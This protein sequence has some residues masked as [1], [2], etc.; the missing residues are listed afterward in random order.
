M[1]VQK[2]G[3]N[4]KAYRQE[5]QQGTKIFE[6]SFKGMQKAEQQKFPEK[7]AEYE[8]STQEALKA[9]QDA[10]KGLANAHLNQL[11]DQLAHDYQSYLSSPSKENEERVQHD[12]DDLKGSAG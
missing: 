9:I 7:K 11:K 10:C 4:A 6:E 2:P 8:K 1:E 5:I 12:I 3:D